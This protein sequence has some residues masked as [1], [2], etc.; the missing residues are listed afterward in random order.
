MTDDY[1]MPAKKPEVIFKDLFINTN[2]ISRRV[3]ACPETSGYRPEAITDAALAGIRNELV[4]KIA[5]P[6]KP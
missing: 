1:K 3:E 6:L 5:T 2:Q 4:F